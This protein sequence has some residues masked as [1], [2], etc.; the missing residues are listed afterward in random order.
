MQTTSS[1]F[2][3]H[4]IESI[5]FDD[6]HYAICAK[7][8][9]QYISY[10]IWVI[11]PLILKPVHVTIYCKVSKLATIVEGDVKVPFS[12]ATS[13][14]CKGGR[15]FFPWIPPLYPWFLQCWV[16]SKAASSTIF[17]SLWYDSTWDWT[18]VSRT[19]SEYST[20]WANGLITCKLK[21]S[22]CWYFI[23]HYIYFVF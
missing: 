7:E 4:V 23:F 2:R 5:S 11:I 1:K 21:D 12:R 20:H 6:N 19:I 14:R 9:I 18:P 10:G 16:S 22:G 15:Y 3:T 8:D 17:L 13:P